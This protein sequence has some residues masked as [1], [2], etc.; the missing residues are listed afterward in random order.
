[1]HKLHSFFPNHTWLQRSL[2]G[3]VYTPTLLFCVSLRFVFAIVNACAD[4]QIQVL[5]SI[6]Y[7]TMLFFYVYI[8]WCKSRVLRQCKYLKER[9]FNLMLEVKRAVSASG[10]CGNVFI[11]SRECVS[12]ICVCVRASMH[13][14]KVAATESLSPPHTPASL[15]DW[16]HLP[17]HPPNFSCLPIKG[18]SS[19]SCRFPSPVWVPQL[20]LSWSGS[21]STKSA[22]LPLYQHSIQRLRTLWFLKKRQLCSSQKTPEPQKRLILISQ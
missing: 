3:C 15:Q 18:R 20:L 13:P 6:F 8:L 14:H 10:I 12:G 5:A 11:P 21:G 17:T 4:G 9:R 1:M 7:I 22:T 2:Q 19:P 16:A